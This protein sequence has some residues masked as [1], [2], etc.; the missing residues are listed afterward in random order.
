MTRAMFRA[1]FVFRPVELRVAEKLQG[2]P[3]GLKAPFLQL[4]RMTV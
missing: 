2:F 3:R 4:P 1:A